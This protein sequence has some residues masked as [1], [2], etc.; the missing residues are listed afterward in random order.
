MEAKPIPVTIGNKFTVCEHCESGLWDKSKRK[1]AGTL[2]NDGY[3][4][5]CFRSE[6]YAA[7]RVVWFLVNNDDPGEL[8][9]DHKDRNKSNNK[10]SN[11]RVVT[12]KQNVNNRVFSKPKTN[13]IKIYKRKRS[14]GYKYIAVRY[15]NRKQVYLGTFNTIT[16]AENYVKR[17]DQM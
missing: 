2:N 5:V 8:E 9:I 1:P 10:I 4:H 17:H 7:H 15:V 14:K 12:H 13:T 3:W 6:R 16:D 11:L